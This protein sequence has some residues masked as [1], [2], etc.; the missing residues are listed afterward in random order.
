[1]LTDQAPGPAFFDFRNNGAGGK[2]FFGPDNQ[3][4]ADTL[5]AMPMEEWYL[6]VLAD[7]T[8]DEKI[9]FAPIKDRS[10]NPMSFASG[11]AWVI[12]ASAKNKD[13][14]CEFMR[15]ITLPDTWYAAAK[16]RADKRAADKKSFTGVYTGNK[17][18]DD[19]I[20][21][22]LVNDQTAGQF[23][24][25]VQVVQQVADTSFELPPIPAAEQFDRIWRGAVDKVM[26]QGADAAQTLE[27][28]NQEAQDAIDSA[29]P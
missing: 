19:R 11:G 26:N 24:P 4:A 6:N 17:A 18:A 27:Q 5:G 12:P 23:Y 25:G 16:V 20:F 9:S 13:A 15:V 1:L 29:G 10:G 3:F 22:D 8:P 28:A 2:D 21:G 7:N 14:A